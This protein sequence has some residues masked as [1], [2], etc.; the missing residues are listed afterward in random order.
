VILPSRDAI[1]ATAAETIA[2]GSKSFGAASKL[3]DRK[4]RERAWLLYAW[5]RACDDLADGQELGHEL[6]RVDDPAARLAEIRARTEAVLRGEWV[7]DPSFDGLR[8]VVAEARIPPARLWDVVEGFALDAAGWRPRTE[9]DLLRYCY[10][11]AGAV[12]C[13]MALVMSVPPEDEGTL[14]RACDLG[15]AFQL[16]N[17][18][19]DLAEDAA[20]GR[21]YLPSDWLD[22]LGVPADDYAAPAYR[23]QLAVL[24]RR[25]TDLA[26]RYEASARVGAAQLSF[27]SAWAVLAAAGIYGDIG[28]EVAARGPAA[29]D[30]R[31]STSKAA[32]LAWIARAFGQARTRHRLHGAR[33]PDLWTRAALARG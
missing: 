22:E 19:R 28:R 14:D 20:G 23:P 10:H 33:D 30:G 11:V 4:T 5:C 15:L 13:L 29:W 32:K 3:F 9:A 17:I 12:G 18:A 25:L 26:A 27:R 31:V 2:E 16:A 7:G 6:T 24:A 1:V 8:F 21:R